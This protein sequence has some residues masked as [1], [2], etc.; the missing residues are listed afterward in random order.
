M[1]RSNL[2][3]AVGIGTV[4]VAGSIGAGVATLGLIWYLDR[5]RGRPGA[6]WFMIALG[7]Q[8]LWCLAYGIGLVVPDPTWR[9]NLEALMWVGMTW[10]G[11]L[12]LAFGLDYTGR[13]HVIHSPSFRALFAVPTITTVLAL[14][15]P[16]HDLLWTG[17]QVTESLDVAAAVY[18]IQPWGYVA[19][20][21]GTVCA[22]VGVLLLIETVVSYGPLYRREAAAVAFSTVPPT[23]G[24]VAWLAGV[25][26]YPELHLAPALFL[27]HVALDAYA[28][29][30]TDMFETNP[31]TMRSA[32][33]TAID[34]LPNPVVI[35]DTDG[36]IVELNTAAE[37]TFGCEVS[38]TRYTPVDELVDLEGD[39]GDRAIERVQTVARAGERGVRKFSVSTTALTE[40]GG[41]TV[42]RTIVLQDVTDEIERKQQLSVLNR[43]LRHNLRNEMT[44]IMGAADVIG[45]S[46]DD[47]EVESW[48]T[49]LRESG[50]EL[51]EIGERAR[52]FEHVRQR[53]PQFESTDVGR[54]LLEAVDAVRETYPDATVD[55][56]LE[57]AT[58]VPTDP[59]ILGVVLSNLLENAIVHD[60]RD[61]PTV[62]IRGSPGRS[63]YTITIEDEG[64]GIHETE[65]EVI[66]R[67]DEDA[68]EHGSGLGLWIVNW[69]VETLGAEIHFESRE[70][71][72]TVRLRVPN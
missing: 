70:N 34:D 50:Q 26:P 52:E 10:T 56:D 63:W 12:F 8:V 16:Y 65:L 14:S 27:A 30:G 44:V 17:F 62:R 51:I 66:D 6:G 45:H 23:L 28:F 18:S 11:P 46:S 38:E 4:I 42:G 33:R 13:G 71:G 25:G 72:T 9:A 31:T 54:T 35:V 67:G 2:F 68:L 53:E 37:S 36:R 5:Y 39:D 41:K 57:G 40:P 20:A 55:V 15:Y 59:E 64:P 47:P 61:E 22:G 21:V 24:L 3:G 19:I 1:F 49:E 69:G 43:I 29:V 58:T 48:L 60:E 32:K 7:S